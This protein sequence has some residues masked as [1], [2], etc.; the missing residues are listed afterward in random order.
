[1]HDHAHVC[2][3]V[4]SHALTNIHALSHVCVCVWLSVCVCVCMCV[5]VRASA[6]V[7]V[8]VC[9]CV[10]VGVWTLVTDGLCLRTFGYGGLLDIVDCG[11]FGS[12]LRPD[13]Y[14]LVLYLYFSACNKLY[15]FVSETK[16]G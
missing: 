1:M 11:S 3:C 4:F 9:A 8:C 6:L 10:C 2:V 14:G 15:I 5:C 7:F 12:G 16:S 13:S